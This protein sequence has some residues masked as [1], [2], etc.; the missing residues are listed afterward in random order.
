M[1]V[2]ALNRSEATLAVAV[3]GIAGPGGGSIVKPV[4]TVC[5]AWARRSAPVSRA[6]EV[7]GQTIAVSA[8]FPGDRH[9]IRMYTARLAIGAALEVR[10]S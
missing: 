10:K 1:A 6:G 2:G 7:A 9:A 5:V 8:R 3:S 4:G